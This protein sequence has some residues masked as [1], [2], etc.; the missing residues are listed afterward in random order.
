MPTDMYTIQIRQRG[1]VTL[2]T[3]L[4]EAYG[5]GEH[6]VLTLLDLGGAF[7]L[8]PQVSMISKLTRTIEKKR[9]QRGVSVQELLDNL[10]LDRH[11]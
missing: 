8:S 2:P 3:A 10:H 1:A 4:R 9:K 11:S 6:G 7:V 5:L